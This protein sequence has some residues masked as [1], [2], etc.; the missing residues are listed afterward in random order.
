[1]RFNKSKCKVLH[2]GLGNPHYQ[3]QLGDQRI[4]CSPAEKHLEVLVNGKLYMS[5][6]CAFTAQKVNCILGCNKRYMTSRV[7]EA[8]LPLFSV[9]VMPHLDY[10]IQMRSPQYWRDIDLLECIQRR[11]TKI[12]HGME[13]R[14]YEDM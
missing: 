7:K 5:Q 13:H 10:C 9:L 6:Q 11:A 14:F 3:Y 1:M 12:I 2:L 8:I 4:E